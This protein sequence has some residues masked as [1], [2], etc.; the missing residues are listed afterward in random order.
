MVTARP[1][2]AWPGRRYR[3]LPSAAVLTVSARHRL[4]S[5]AFRR[6]C[7]HRRRRR[8]RRRR[9][10][11]PFHAA[12]RQGAGGTDVV[13]ISDA[14]ITIDAV[15][16]PIAPS[17]QF[18]PPTLGA[19]GSTGP[20][21]PPTWVAW[22][23]R[24]H[25]SEGA[26]TLPRTTAGTAVNRP[27]RRNHIPPSPPEPLTPSPLSLPPAPPNR[28]HFAATGAAGCTPSPAEYW[29]CI[30]ATNRRWV[31]P[32]PYWPPAPYATHTAE[33]FATCTALTGP[34]RRQPPAS[35]AEKP[36]PPP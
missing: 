21:E 17:V 30:Y 5:L 25:S 22:C 8:C 18:T 27:R 26:Q 23:R 10:R 6:A 7:Q 20:A 11:H 3:Q 15:D 14:T 34:R 29:R 28:R 33:P 2:T 4:G 9:R 19:F 31:T 36:V 13:A 32:V 16:P 12:H 35:T 1:L 24:C